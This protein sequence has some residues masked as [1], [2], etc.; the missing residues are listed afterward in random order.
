MS[1]IG[2]SAYCGDALKL[3]AT[4]PDDRVN[5]VMSSSPFALIRKKEY[6]NKGQHEYVEWLSEFAKLVLKKLTPDGSFVLDLGGLSK[7]NTRKKSL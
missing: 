5:L 7:R 6:G 3:L 2:G 4:F 1:Q